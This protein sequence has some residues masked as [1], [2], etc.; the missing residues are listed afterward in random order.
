MPKITIDILSPSSVREAQRQ[1]EAFYNSFPY[2]CERLT[3][4]LVN[5]ARYVIEAQISAAQITYDEKG[6]QS[7]ADVS[8]STNVS[9]HTMGDITRAT[10]TV[11]GEEIAFIEFGAGVY[12]N[13]P[14]G[15]SSHPLGSRF[16]FVIGSY[17]KGHGVQK[18]WGFYDES[19]KLVLT[20]GVRATMPMYNAL[21][22]M[23]KEAR[24]LAREIF[25]EN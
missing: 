1:I 13:V 23:K 5:R 22:W 4:E 6:I 24:A 9:Y 3:R 8:H 2:K 25:M 16:G 20:H 11:S 18:V 14:A 12:H 10:I 15:T 21:L 19:G 7:G 17:G